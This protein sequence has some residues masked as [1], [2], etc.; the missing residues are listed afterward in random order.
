MDLTKVFAEKTVEKPYEFENAHL[1]ELVRRSGVEEKRDMPIGSMGQSH[2]KA[3]YA[4]LPGASLTDLEEFGKACRKHYICFPAAELL[5]MDTLNFFEK[6][7]IWRGKNFEFPGLG[8]NFLLQTLNESEKVSEKNLPL[9]E[10]IFDVMKKGLVFHEET[11]V[12]FAHF[13]QKHLMQETET[14]KVTEKGNNQVWFS[15]R[16]ENKA[17]RKAVFEKYPSF[18][19]P[20]IR[21]ALT[22][23]EQTLSAQN[24]KRKVANTTWN[25]I[26]H[27]FEEVYQLGPSAQ[28]SI[29][30]EIKSYLSIDLSQSL[31][32]EKKTDGKKVMNLAFLRQEFGKTGSPLFVL[33]TDILSEEQGKLEKQQ[34]EMMAT[35]EQQRQMLAAT[36]LRIVDFSN[37]FQAVF[38]AAISGHTV[39]AY[40]E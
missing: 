25:K 23:L 4:Y 30:A 14:F 1:A 26:A 11:K 28:A 19:A 37:H 31:K 34:K 12:S 36:Q 35:L 13:L 40:G 29:T 5:T 24:S 18:V 15:D 9:M 33:L 8:V 7:S 22:E 2:A 16:K 3:V 32:E 38:T 17:F 10:E 20:Y 21:Q 6:V 27:A 39:R